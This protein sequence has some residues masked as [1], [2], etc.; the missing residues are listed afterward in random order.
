MPDL[1]PNLFDTLVVY[2]KDFFQKKL[3]LK[4]IIRRQTGTKNSKVGKGLNEC[5][6]ISQE[7]R[8]IQLSFV[9]RDYDK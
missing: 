1:D 2:W 3:I 4:I 8:R 6:I 9:N 5:V 7:C